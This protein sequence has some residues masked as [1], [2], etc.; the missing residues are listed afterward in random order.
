MRPK[1]RQALIRRHFEAVRDVAW[2][3]D[4]EP[5]LRAAGTDNARM[6]GFREAWNRFAEA[7][8]W[9]WWRAESARYS[10]ERLQDLQMGAVER[11]DALAGS[12]YRER[13]AEA[14]GRPVN[15]NEKGLE[16]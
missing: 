3:E 12:Q 14:A 2:A 13:L 5:K 10:D 7:K 6:Q 16:R 8:D 4:L 9:P 1:D 15:D 11:G